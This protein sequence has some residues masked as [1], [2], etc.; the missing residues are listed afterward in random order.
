MSE[1]EDK[2][3]GRV[4]DIPTLNAS[5]LAPNITKRNIFGPGRFWDEW[6]MR[7]FILPAHESIPPHK[8]DWEHLLYTI[9]GNGEVEVEGEHYDMSKG[10]WARVPSGKEHIFRNLG[11]E[12]FEFFC[13]VPASGDPHAK[14]I[15]MRKARVT[16]KAAKGELV[17]SCSEE[18]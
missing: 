7:N 11:E 2:N 1:H 9:S 3:F 4:A 18:N 15:K 10:N 5:A 14:K 17:P 16:C 6:V 12:P 8:H 13:I